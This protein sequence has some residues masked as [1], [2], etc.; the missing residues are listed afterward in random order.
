MKFLR[1]SLLC[2]LVSVSA[3]AETVVLV[4]GDAIHGEIIEK[5]DSSIILVHD[6]LGT[7]QIPKD[8]IANTTVL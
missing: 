7:L 2:V 4:R 1:L 3:Q 5:T 6:V 8:Q